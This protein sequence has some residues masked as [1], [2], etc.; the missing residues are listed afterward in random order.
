MNASDPQPSDEQLD[1]QA[2]TWLCER[3]EGFSPERA[4]AFAAWRR[5]DLRREA[6]LRRVEEMLTLL[7]ALPEVRVPLEARLARDEPAV[8]PAGRGRLLHLP[9]AVWAAGLAAAVVIGTIM[10]WQ[11][12]EPAIERMAYATEAETQRRIALSDGSLVDLNS[13]STLTIAFGAGER[14]VTL[15]AGEAHFQ[16]A[17]D[18]SRPFIVTAG[19]V[20]VRAVGTAFN[21][22]L[23]AESIDVLV[24][25]GKVEVSRTNEP[26]EAV[27]P[28]RPLVAAGEQTRVRR[29][30]AANPPTVEKVAAEAIRAQLAWQSRLIPF[31]DLPL[32]D[33]VAQFNRRNTTQ[34]VLGDPVLEERRV[35]GMI[36]LDQLDAFVRL[37][38]QDGD[39]AVERGPSNV[40]VLRQVR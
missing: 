19:G 16:V 25:E 33:L 31:V 29:D 37:L 9:R 4:K 38:E 1:E 28:V 13:A 6:A 10:W 35:G 18:S 27:E 40:I 8:A 21:V 15:D 23:A 26:D 3:E 30:S 17:H 2:A 20:S 12:P 39:I 32:R 24:V 5:D 7:D 34:L 22:K 14:R 11:Q 36:A